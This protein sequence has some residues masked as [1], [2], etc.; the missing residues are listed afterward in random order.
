MSGKRVVAEITDEV[1]SYCKSCGF[2]TARRKDKKCKVCVSKQ[3]KFDIN[4]IG[5]TING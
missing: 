2:E 5:A 4:S 1:F 3:N